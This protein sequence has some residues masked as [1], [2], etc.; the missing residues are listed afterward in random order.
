VTLSHEIQAHDRLYPPVDF[1][2]RTRKVD[3]DDYEAV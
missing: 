1:R 2:H 3:I